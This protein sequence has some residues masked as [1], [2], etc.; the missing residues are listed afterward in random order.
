MAFDIIP[1]IDLKDGKA[2]RGIAGNRADYRPLATPLCPDGEPLTAVRGYLGLYPFSRLYIA[3]LD[4]IEGGTRQD[5]VLAAIRKSFPQLKLWVDAGFA[6]PGHA[7]EWSALGLGRPILGSESLI[8]AH[9]PARGA[10][11][12]LDFRGDRFLGPPALLDDPYLW[13]RDVIVMCLDDVGMGAGPDL[14]RLTGI[15]AVADEQRIYAAGGVRGPAD[16]RALA[17][18]G[19]SGALVA[20]A[21]HNGAISADDLCAGFAI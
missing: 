17:A 6:S 1:V 7:R 14:E 13:P 15:I 9:R 12:S 11:L 2:V 16:L 4:A 21:L 10:V 8:A 18:L 20:S 5:A 19:A 3:D